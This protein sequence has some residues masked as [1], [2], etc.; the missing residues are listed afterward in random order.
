MGDI[1]LTDSAVIILFAAAIG[2]G[3]MFSMVTTAFMPLFNGLFIIPMAWLA[4]RLGN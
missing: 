2:A 3:D 4:A 1:T